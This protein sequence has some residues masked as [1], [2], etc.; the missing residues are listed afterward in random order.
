MPRSG[1]GGAPGV[2]RQTSGPGDLMV[3]TMAS[4]QTAATTAVTTARVSSRPWL[5]PKHDGRLERAA[6]RDDEG[7]SGDEKPSEQRQEHL[8]EGATCR[9]Q[10][11]GTG[12]TVL[13]RV[14]TSERRALREPS[15]R[16]ADRVAR[17]VTAVVVGCS[18]VIAA[19][20]LLAGPTWRLRASFSRRRSRVSEAIVH[21]HAGACLSP[22]APG[23]IGLHT[24]AR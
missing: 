1:A 5:V 23:G 17:V 13:A 19:P 7:D 11:A 4:T 18:D 15:P 10:Q 20:S 2:R 22:S 12:A 24:P 3:T 6:V 14:R 8:A 16:S 21:R 9:G